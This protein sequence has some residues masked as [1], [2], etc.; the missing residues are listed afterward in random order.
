MKR[1]FASQVF[2]H[3]ISADALQ[4]IF[5]SSIHLFIQLFFLQKNFMISFINFPLKTSAIS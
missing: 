1:N 3:Y 4:H 5:L 2:H